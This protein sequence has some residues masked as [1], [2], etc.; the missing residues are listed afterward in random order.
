MN[1]E[2]KTEV[3]GIL[4]RHEGKDRAITGREL[5]NLFGYRNDRQIRLIIRELIAEGWPIASS[6][7]SPF[8]YFIVATRKEAEQYAVSIRSRLI[9]DALRRRDFRRAVDQ[10][11]TPAI[12]G[13]ML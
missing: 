3:K 10:Y 2:L 6:T 9:E 8:G 1:G 12:Q 5:A 11:L 7:E 4:L 13:K